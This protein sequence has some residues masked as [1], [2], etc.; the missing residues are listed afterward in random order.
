[1]QTPVKDSAPAIRPPGHK[2]ELMSLGLDGL[3]TALQEGIQSIKSIW[4]CGCKYNAGALMNAFLHGVSLLCPR[5]FPWL[6]QGVT[7][8]RPLS[9]GSS[10]PYNPVRGQSGED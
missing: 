1:M 3:T 8:H 9:A 2:G 5:G 7:C 4:Y 10:S 6:V